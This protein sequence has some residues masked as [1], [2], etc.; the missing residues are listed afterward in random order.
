MQ[1]V[2][3]HSFDTESIFKGISSIKNETAL[4]LFSI[5][6]TAPPLAPLFVITGKFKLFLI[7]AISLL[8][9]QW[10]YQE[11][12]RNFAE[13]NLKHHSFHKIWID[14]YSSQEYQDVTD[15]LRNY[16][17][18]IGKSLNKKEIENYKELFR[19]GIEYEIGFWDSAWNFLSN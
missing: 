8:P 4:I 17:D 13:N 5:F 16:V 2:S 11:I 7:I 15:W 12:A 9:C 3:G 1:C 18:K 19:L 10:G 14:S 6:F